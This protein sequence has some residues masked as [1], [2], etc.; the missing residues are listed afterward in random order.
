MDNLTGKK[1]TVSAS[2][3]FTAGALLAWPGGGSL[4]FGTFV[5]PAQSTQTIL[6]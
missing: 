4:D 2:Y 3:T 6:F 5:F 1:V